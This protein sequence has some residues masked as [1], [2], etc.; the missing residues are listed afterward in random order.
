V[1]E[2]QRFSEFLASAEQHATQWRDTYRLAKLPDEAV[3]APR[4]ARALAASPCSSRTGA[5]TP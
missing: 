1:G 3:R 4:R 5:A 2:R